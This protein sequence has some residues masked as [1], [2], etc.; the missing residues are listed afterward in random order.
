MKILNFIVETSVGPTVNHILS[1]CNSESERNAFYFSYSAFTTLQKN[2][3]LSGDNYIFVIARVVELLR[4]YGFPNEVLTAAWIYKVFVYS[5]ASTISTLSIFGESV[6]NMVKCLSPVNISLCPSKRA[7]RSE[8]RR[9]LLNSNRECKSIKCAELLIHSSFMKKRSLL[10]ANKYQS[11]N[12]DLLLSLEGA[13]PELFEAVR[14]MMRT[15][16]AVDN[17]LNYVKSI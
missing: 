16:E 12:T 4:I 9:S 15:N 3:P 17:L 10:A 2:S 8:E 13:S 5:P 14:T 1:K 7:R 11:E 6:T